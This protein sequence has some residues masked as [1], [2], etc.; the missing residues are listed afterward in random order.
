M[1]D[2]GHLLNLFHDW[3]PDENTRHEILIETPAS[4]FGK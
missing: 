2:D 1:P 3:T 4:L